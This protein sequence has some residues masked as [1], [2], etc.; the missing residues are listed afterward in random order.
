M[1]VFTVLSYN[2]R[3]G[4]MDEWFKSHAWTTRHAVA[5]CGVG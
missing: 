3:F 2:A 5:C 4:E 1:T